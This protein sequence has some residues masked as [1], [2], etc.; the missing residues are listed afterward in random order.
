MTDRTTYPVDPAHLHTGLEPRE[1]S[2]RRRATKGRED[3]PS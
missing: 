2:D 1:E 3:V